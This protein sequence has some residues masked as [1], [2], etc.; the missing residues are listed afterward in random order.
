MTWNDIT[1]SKFNQL[2]DIFTDPDFDENDRLLYEMQILFDVDPFKLSI[3]QLSYFASQ[4][5]FLGEK[6]PN[7]KVKDTYKLGGRK[8]KLKK[9]LEEYNVAMWIDYTNFIKEGGS[10]SDNY[11]KLL[12]V[13]LWP[14]NASEYNEGYNI[15]EVREDIDKYLTIPDAVAIAGFFLNRLKALSIT[16]QLY[17]KE[18]TMK[19]EMPKERKKEIRRKLRKALW[20]TLTA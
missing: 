18:T 11:P 9:R 14:E 2:T 8:Y 6:I 7:M 13:F 19:N 10:G 20:K 1:I 16:F 15:E 3:S 17:I 5:K 12:S 4:M